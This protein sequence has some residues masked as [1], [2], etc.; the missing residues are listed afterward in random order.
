MLNKNTFVEV[1][2]DQNY[3][4]GH[5]CP[6]DIFLSKRIDAEGRIVCVLADGLGSGIKA[7]VL[8]T[9]TATMAVKY[10]LSDIDV[11]TASEIIMST[12]P[13]CSERKIGY[14]T[15]TIIDIHFDGR[16]RVIEYD[17]PPYL[18]LRDGQKVDIEKSRISV[19]IAD[20]ERRDVWYSS[21]TAEHGDRAVVYS[22]GVTQS[23]MG[24]NSMPLGWGDS[25]EQHVISLCKKDLSIS[26]RSL[27]KNIVRKALIND[28]KVAKDDITCAAINFR[29][30]R[31]LLVVTGPPLDKRRDEEIAM[32]IKDYSGKII[33]CGGT[34]SNIVSRQLGRPIDVMFSTA[35][36]NV[37]PAAKMEGVCLITEG[38][39]TLNAAADILDHSSDP[40]KLKPDAA[41]KLVR[42]LLD[43][44]MISF[45]VGTKINDA[46]QN[47][48]LPI[49]LDIRRNLVKRIVNR[50]NEKYMKKA[51]LR[52]I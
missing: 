9:L 21:F 31:E 48:N 37:P 23:G 24:T 42:H 17:N 30:P 38:M 11:K 18:L 27:S 16:V 4:A 10:I 19:E 47:P 14:S 39:L 12:L 33:I 20:K 1:D 2:Y 13:I 41:V 50:L 51:Q 26:A 28:L 5:D 8:A 36:E 34:T 29:K 3:K 52:F 6:G 44:D 43:S 49:E 7:N 22:D 15:F 35:S 40:E 32:M 45:V 46:H 25:A